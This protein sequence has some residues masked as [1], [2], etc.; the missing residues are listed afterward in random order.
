[1]KHARPH[2]KTPEIIRLWKLNLSKTD[3]ARLVGCTKANVTQTIRRH[4]AWDNRVE[5]LSETHHEWLVK[6][7]S[8]NYTPPAV[9]ARALLIDAIEEAMAKEVSR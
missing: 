3:I 4:L 6:Q 1:M 2:S 7:A 9:M 8:R 5:G